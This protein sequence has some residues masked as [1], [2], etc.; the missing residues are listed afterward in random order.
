MFALIKSS[1][2]WKEA[3]APP[4]V[5]ILG[6]RIPVDGTPAH[7]LHL[8][9]TNDCG[10]LTFLHRV[11]DTRRYWPGKESWAYRDLNRLDCQLDE[12]VA[13]SRHLQQKEHNDQEVDMRRYSSTAEQGQVLRQRQRQLFGDQQHH[14]LPQRYSSC[15]GAYYVYYSFDV[16][17]LPRNAFVPDWIGKI[18]DEFPQKY[19]GDVFVVKMGPQEYGPYGW[20]AYEDITPEFLELLSTGPLKSWKED[21]GFRW[22]WKA[23]DDRSHGLM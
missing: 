5:T 11:P 23:S 10:L 7:L 16:D 15:I 21:V 9:T 1:L 6:V 17:H 8:T 20:A 3:P 14:L 22:P 18:G 4:P 19:C 2:G 12:K 13:R